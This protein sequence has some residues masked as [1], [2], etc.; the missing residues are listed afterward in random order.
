MRKLTIGLAVAALCAAAA[1]S[2]VCEEMTWETK[3]PPRLIAVQ[4]EKPA[5]WAYICIFYDAQTKVMYMASRNGAITPM[6]DRFGN[7]VLYTED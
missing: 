4:Q 2:G 6:I 5:T 1:C 7:P 3:A